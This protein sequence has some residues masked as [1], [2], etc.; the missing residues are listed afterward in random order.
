VNLRKFDADAHRNSKGKVFLS[1][2]TN[3]IDEF[4]FRQL[5]HTADFIRFK[6]FARQA[7][8]GHCFELNCEDIADTKA[9]ADQI[10]SFN[11]FIKILDVGI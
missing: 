9:I 11:F 8:L 7:L 6:M 5:I 4:R 2:I 10:F 3:F 1:A